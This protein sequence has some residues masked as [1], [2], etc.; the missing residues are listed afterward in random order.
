[1][2]DLCLMHDVSCFYRHDMIAVRELLTATACCCPVQG[3]TGGGV[4][5][6]AKIVF[7]VMRLCSWV[8]HR[9]C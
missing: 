5:S 7:V 3:I 4:D 8:P 9:P 1:M 6:A 2:E